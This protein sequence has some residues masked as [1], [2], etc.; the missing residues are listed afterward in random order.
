MRM[1]KARMDVLYVWEQQMGHQYEWSENEERRN[2]DARAD[3]ILECMDDECGKVCGSKAAL[4]VR[5][6]QMH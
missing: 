2:R 1:V 3:E 5:H 6:R 4:T